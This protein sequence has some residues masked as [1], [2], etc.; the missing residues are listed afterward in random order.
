[1]NIVRTFHDARTAIAALRLAGRRIALVPTMGALHDGHLSLIEAAGGDEH[2][3]VVTIFVN[4]AQFAAGEDLASYP[5]DLHRDT[6]LA[7]RAG[8]SVL[9]A[10]SPPEVYPEG[11]ATTIVIEGPAD[12]LEGATRPTHFAGVATVVAKLL[13]ALRPDRVV[14]GQKDAQQVAVIRRL[15]RDLHLDDIDLLVAPTARE[16]DGL[17]MS[18]RNTYLDD[19]GRRAAAALFRA[20]SAIE[21]RVREGVHD[22]DELRAT[23]IDVLSADPLCQAEYVEVVDP[24]SFAPLDRLDRP[25]LAVVAARVGSTRLIDNIKLPAPQPTSR[26]ANVSPS[27]RTMLKSKIHRA[28]VTD[29]NLNYVGSI[30]VDSD[31]LGAADIRPYEHVHVVNI[32]NGA[33]FETYAI[34]GA[35]GSGTICLN[36]GAARLANPGDLVIVL[37]YA[38]YAESELD[39]YEPVIV[40]VDEDNRRT[41]LV[42]AVLAGI[43]SS[44]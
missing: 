11:F 35:P 39:G 9:L 26:R 38:T 22:L 40:Q 30:T 41:D 33:R 21:R 31:L 34:E 43:E 42:D 14:F 36:G 3:V 19:D 12:G 20:L 8:A 4:P 28:T 17:A 5:R 15:M 37:S 18:S 16:A 24:D 23:G 2:E 25:S 10:P 29:A 1:M 27:T 32:N 13:I 44:R 7:E 6:E